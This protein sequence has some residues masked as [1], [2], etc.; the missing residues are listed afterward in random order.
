MARGSEVLQMQQFCHHVGT[1]YHQKSGYVTTTLHGTST[2]GCNNNAIFS[3]RVI[4][5]VHTVTYFDHVN[6]AAKKPW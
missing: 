1:I 2:R 6:L 5:T 4:F 3:D